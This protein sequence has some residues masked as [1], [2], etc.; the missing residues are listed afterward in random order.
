MTD[1][2]DALRR[3]RRRDSISKRA[4]AAETLQTMVESGVAISFPAVARRA[5]VSVSLLYDDADLAGRISDARDRQR[6]AGADRAWCLPARSL[7]TEQSL[8]ADLANAREQARQLGEE[9]TLLRSRLARDLG[10]GA[11]VA[12]GRLA[13]P[14]V[15]Q[16]ETRAAE[17]EADNHTMRRRIGELENEVTEL[18]ATL[19]TAR[20]MNREM[21]S[22]VNRLDARPADQTPR[23]TARRRR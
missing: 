9:V 17:L 10:A 2:S 12:R 19:E 8:R 20:A 21:M 6:Q 1:N 22:E 15:D 16:L 13:S 23:T 14:L 11:D 3:S 5:G 7:V 4:L 18:T